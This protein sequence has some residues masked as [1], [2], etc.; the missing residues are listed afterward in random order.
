[1]RKL[2]TGAFA[3][4]AFAVGTMMTGGAAHAASCNVDKAGGDLSFEEAKG[5]YDCLSE[6]MNKGYQKGGKRW[7]PAEYVADYRSWGAAS[8]GP[9][10][11]GTHGGRFLMAY[12]NDIGFEQYTK[13]AEDVVMPTG[14]VIAK[15]S[16]TVSKKGKAKAGPLFIME[17]VAPGT[18]PE[19]GDWYY[20]MVSAKGKPQAV[21]VVSACHDCHS[22][23]DY[24]G[25][26][27]Y[28]VEEVRLGQ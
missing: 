1:M 5:V 11:P 6:K 28:P 13:Y 12:V 9:A 18:S 26:M 8:T 21:N 17:K 22:G 24:Q 25:F 4:A 2:T 20:M 23:F 16:F 15:E 27:G 10:A 7:I 19:T 14:T 3:A